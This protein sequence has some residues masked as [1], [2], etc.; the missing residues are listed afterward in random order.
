MSVPTNTF[1]SF[2]AVGNRE[3][4]SDLIYNIDPTETPFASGIERVKTAATL[5]EWQT[6]ALA[7]ANSVNSVLEG[8]DASNDTTTA[9]TRLS[10]IHQISR[11]VAQVSGT[12]RVVDH[13]GR[14][15]ELDYQKMLKGKELKRDME[16][17]LTSNQ[18]KATG[19]LATIRGVASV[20]SWIFTNTSKGTNGSDPIANGVSSRTDGSMRAFTEALL[21]GVLQ[22][23]WVNGGQP[24]TIMVG[25]FNKQNFS[26]FTG[27]S[28]PIEE[29]ASRRIVAAVDVYESD[30]GRLKVVPNRFM[31]SRDALVLQ[32]DMWA[33]G[34]LP[35]RN[36]VAFPLAKTGDS[37]R[38]EVLTEYTLEGRNEKA[39]GGVFDLTSA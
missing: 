33:L 38:W 10:N 31:R 32:M 29:A 3:D 8:D 27:R 39:S 11:K 30:F 7:A 12:Q 19:A 16:A 15:D 13:A 1:T 2:S 21:K 25:G 6:Q 37:D 9:T 18:Q 4:L 20:L 22:S 26:T 5:H 28:S 35:G 17:V 24:D 23:A 14:G 34:A 36:F